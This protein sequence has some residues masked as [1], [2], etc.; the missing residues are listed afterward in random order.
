MK[1]ENDIFWSSLANYLAALLASCW[2]IGVP[3]RNEEI[4]AEPS[5]MYSLFTETFWSEDKNIEN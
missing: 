5:N 2:P 3:Q 4:F 1:N